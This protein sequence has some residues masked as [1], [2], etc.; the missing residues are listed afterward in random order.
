[1]TVAAGFITEKQTHSISIWNAFQERSVEF[2]SMSSVAPDGT[3]MPTPTLPRTIPQSGDVVLT[4]TID[5][6]GPPIQETY[7]RPLVNGVTYSI[8]ITGIRV[9]GLWAGPT[10]EKGIQIS[11]GFET[12][13]FQTDRFEE[14][15]RPLMA[16]PYRTLTATFPIYSRDAHKFFYDLAYG[17]DKLFGVP[18]YNEMLLVDTI[19]QGSATITTST[20]TDNMYNLNNLSSYIAVVDHDNGMAEIKEVSS[21]TPSYTITTTNAM[22]ADFAADTTRVYPIF[23]GLIQS[24][25][26]GHL[27]DDVEVVEIEFQEF[28]S[29]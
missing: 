20:P 10:W 27:T 2:T 21:I 1:L 19:T 18:I 28:N 24:V 16:N 14:Q 5:Q 8:Y 26:S 4:L 22:V 11:Y 9:L 7:Y 23:F 12:A 25:R 3:S 29:G 13:M 6:N 17:H 15:R